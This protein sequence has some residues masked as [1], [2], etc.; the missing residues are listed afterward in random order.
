[1]TS[2]RLPR[3]FVW[4]R[5]SCRGKNLHERA[6]VECT[7]CNSLHGKGGVVGPDLAGIGGR[8]SR[9]Y[10]LESIYNPN[11]VIAARLRECNAGLKEWRRKL[12][13]DSEN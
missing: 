4:W 11:K 10:L 9:E 12:A 3:S 2:C 13:W 8:Q 6:G 1:M 7:R 5:R